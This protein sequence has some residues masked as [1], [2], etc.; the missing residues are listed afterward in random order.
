MN[1]SA[2]KVSAEIACPENNNKQQDT[3]AVTIT[4]TA[5]TKATQGSSGATKITKARKKFEVTKQIKG[6]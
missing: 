1:N 6:S 5:T 3:P 4:A 2:K